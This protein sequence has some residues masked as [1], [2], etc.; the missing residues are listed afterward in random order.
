MNAVVGVTD[1]LLDTAGLSDEQTNYIEVI[2]TSGQHLLTV[3]FAL[4]LLLL[5]LSVLAP[6]HE[7]G[8]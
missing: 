1:I 3:S 5:L 7:Y 6:D 8:T 2:R 4:L